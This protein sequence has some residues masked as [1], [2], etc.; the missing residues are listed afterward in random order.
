MV[1]QHHQLNGHEFDQTPGVSGGQESLACCCPWGHKESDM[2]DLVTEKQQRK[3][4]TGEN[5]KVQ[6]LFIADTL[7][8]N[9]EQPL[10]FVLYQRSGLVLPYPQTIKDTS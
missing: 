4:I 8:A 2:N 5:K 3:K 1:R 9:C 6:G 10:I 7:T